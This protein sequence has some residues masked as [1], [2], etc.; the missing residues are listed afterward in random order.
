MEEK[1][2]SVNNSLCLLLFQ[3]G[4]VQC[5]QTTCR[6]TAGCYVILF[7]NFQ[8]KKCCDV[9]KGERFCVWWPMYATKSKQQRKQ[10]LPQPPLHMYDDNAATNDNNNNIIIK[11]IIK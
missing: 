9:C 8:D 2:Y 4:I 5:T 1:K 11:I 3:E 10:P 7:D 6:S